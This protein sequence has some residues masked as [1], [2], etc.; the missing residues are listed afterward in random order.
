MS[1]LDLL[2]L[3]DE[4]VDGGIIREFRRNGFLVRSSIEE[5]PGIADHEVLQQAIELNALLITQ[6]KGYGRHV[7]R[8]GMPPGGL[9]LVRLVGWSSA[10]KAETV[11]E[12]FQKHATGLSGHFAVLDTSGSRVARWP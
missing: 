9:V 11:L 2:V 4:D 10:Q 5:M 12:F 6:D 1:Y 8:Y 7:R 3:A